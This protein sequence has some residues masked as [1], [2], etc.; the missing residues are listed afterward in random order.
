[1]AY[2]ANNKESL[3]HQFI[4]SLGEVMG[5]KLV[6]QQLEVPFNS[7]EGRRS[8]D[9][10][11]TVQMPSGD[12]SAVAVEVLSAAYPRDVRLAAHRLGAYKAAHEG[13]EETLQFVIADHLSAGSRKALREAGI[14]YYDSSGTLYFHHHTWLV[15]VERTS[16]ERKPRRPSTLFTGAREQVIHALLMHW[17]ATEG[18][19]FISGAE[20]AIMA[21]TSTYTVS[22]A[23]QE[24][25][26]QDWVESIGKGPTLRRRVRDAAGLLD[27]WV[28]AWQQ[29]REIVTRWYTYAPGAGGVVDLLLQRLADHDGWALTGAAAANTVVPHLTHVDRAEV[30]V[31][32][33]KSEA[34]ARELKLSRAEK[35]SNVIFI[36]REGASLMFL[37]EHP[38][39]PG[40]RL[41][42]HFIQ[43]LD[44]LDY[45]GRNK[46]LAEEFR[47]RALNIEARK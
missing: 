1:M 12:E 27:A 47:R 7:K 41:A 2:M 16:K 18:R 38:E 6:Q 10:E 36:E 28:A 21:K 26:R 29:R 5:I 22:L 44:L 45:Y 11:L 46:E 25:E 13:S 37:D 35:G 20:L 17:K 34:W 14:N 40:S 8:L 43:Y 32:S 42:S 33:G 23:M 4:T 24:M 3:L 9:A 19:E 30:I 39:R 31:P 15:D